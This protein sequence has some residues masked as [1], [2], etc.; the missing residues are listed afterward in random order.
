MPKNIRLRILI[1]S[2]ILMTAC[3]SATRGSH[4]MI[5]VNSVPQGASAISN[6][7][8]KRSLTFQDGTKSEYFGC[9]P[10]PCG[11]N[12]PRKSDP[13]VEVKKA[14]YQSIKTT[15]LQRKCI[16]A[17]KKRNKAIAKIDERHP[18]K[19]NDYLNSSREPHTTYQ[20]KYSP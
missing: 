15:T 19:S 4:E 10:T 7:K 18:P 12:L 3:A 6:L 14:G 2:T 8:S 20:S 17:V 5:Q 16:S 1:S 13:V 11:I 9:A